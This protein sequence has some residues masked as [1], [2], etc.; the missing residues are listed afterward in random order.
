M[1]G[2]VFPERVSE[3]QARELIVAEPPMVGRDLARQV[4]PPAPVALDGAGA[5]ASAGVDPIRIAMIDTG[6]KRS[7]LDQLTQ[8]GVELTLHPCTVGC[9]RAARERRR[10]LLPGQRARRPGRARLRRRHGSRARWKEAGLRDLPRPPAAVPRRRPGDLQA[11]RSATTAPTTRSRTSPPAGP[12]SRARTMA[13][14][15]LVPVARGGSRAMS[16]CA[17]RPTSARLSSAT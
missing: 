17:G 15:S 6:V 16:R 9:R 7:I 1:L 14:R 12:R 5:G 2:G 8:R 3:A 4:S 11:S 10:R 13:S